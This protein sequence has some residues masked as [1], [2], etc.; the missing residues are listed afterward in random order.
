MHWF[1]KSKHTKLNF[2]G[3]AFSPPLLFSHAINSFELLKLHIPYHWNGMQEKPK[4]IRYVMCT[5]S[6]IFDAL[7]C[8]SFLAFVFRPKYS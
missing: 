8:E 4:T 1:R 7:W 2:L 5:K 3:I 6:S